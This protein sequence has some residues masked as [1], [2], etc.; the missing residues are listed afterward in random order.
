[1]RHAPKLFQSL[2]GLIDRSAGQ[3]NNSG[4]FLDTEQSKSFLVLFFK[5]ELFPYFPCAAA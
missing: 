3:D 1:V 4:R 5:K 2:R